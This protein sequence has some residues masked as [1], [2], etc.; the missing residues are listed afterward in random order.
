MSTM[1]PEVPGPGQESVWDY[2]RPPLLEQSSRLITVRL[3]GVLVAE[4]RDAWRVLETSHPPTWYVPRDDVAADALTPSDTRSTHCEWKG[5][6]TYWDVHG[7][8][9]ISVGAAW[10]YETPT[11]SF[12]P[13]T[14]HLAFSPS[15]LECEVDGE[16]VTPQEGGFYEGWITRD[17]VGPFK[18]IPGSWGW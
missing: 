11:A 14:G 16:R 2:P 9:S 7:H 12:L 17:V 3:Q 4:T 18:G 5:A 13:I 15:R 10:S 6:A 8:D 1:T